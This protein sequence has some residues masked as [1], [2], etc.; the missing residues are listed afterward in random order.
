MTLWLAS[1]RYRV[2]PP[3]VNPAGAQKCAAVPMPSSVAHV[4]TDP[5]MVLVTTVGPVGVSSRSVELPVSA[6]KT[7]PDPSTA[8]PRGELKRAEAPRPSLLPELPR[9]PA[10]VLTLC[11]GVI[12]RMV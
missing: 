8:T 7:L 10:R 11:R 5:A 4:F 6:T 3:M 12:F 1:A 2:L 9:G